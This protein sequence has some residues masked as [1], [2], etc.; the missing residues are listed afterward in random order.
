MEIRPEQVA[1][2]SRVQPRM[3]ME[4]SVQRVRQDLRT[5]PQSAREAAMLVPELTACS[6]I[7]HS[8]EVLREAKTRRRV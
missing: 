4:R 1:L 5:Q 6:C 8:T 7:L 3:K 2:S